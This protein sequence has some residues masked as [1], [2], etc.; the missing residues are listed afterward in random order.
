MAEDVKVPEG[1]RR[2][3][4]GEISEIVKGIT[5][6]SSD[7][8]ESEEGA[9]FINL[10]CILKKGGFNKDGLKYFKG[11]IRE[12]Q[13]LR[14]GDIIIAIVDLT[15]DGDIIG[16]P[17]R[18]PDFGSNKVVTMSMDVVKIEPDAQIDKAFLYYRLCLNDIHSYI[19]SI[20]AGSTVLHLDLNW[21]PQLEFSVPLSLPE[22]RKIAEILETVDNAIEKTDR[23]I[24]KYKRIKQGLMQD[25]LT[26]GIAESDELGVMSY[27][28]R[29]EKKHRFWDS[30]L[31]RIPEEWEVVELGDVANVK[32]GA[33]PRP[34]DNPVYF[35]EGGRGWVRILDVTSSNKYLKRT[36]QYLSPIGEQKSVKVEPNELI[37]SICATIGKPTIVKI[38]A[39]I[40]D[41]FVVFK[42]L[43]SQVGVEYLFYY[44]TFKEKDFQEKGQ[45]GTQGNLNSSLVSS[46][47]LLKP[48]L[49]EQHRIASIL[50][51][52]DEVIEKEQK[53]KEKLERIK[54]GLMEDLLM[55]KVR[56][57]HLIEENKSLEGVENV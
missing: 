35:S 17:L 18:V 51:Q 25:L 24:E 36:T 48:P 52:I 13:I 16:Y 10:K 8:C 9:T 41:G 1:W 45:I 27:E 23:I 42:N 19:L 29:D 53:Y 22:Q 32:R 54:K 55:G 46:F 50:S 28:L 47:K 37:M 31:G 20:S 44:L 15:R 33:S 34:I 7:Y 43:S 11:L 56:V 12:S 30:P 57:N 4:L 6:K 3:R 5:Y 39:C 40:H 14:K 21:L 26:R 38:P 49:P 2:V